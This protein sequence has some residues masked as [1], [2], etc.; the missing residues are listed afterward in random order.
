MFEAKAPIKPPLATITRNVKFNV[1]NFGKNN[2]FP[3][4]LIRAINNSPTAR[5]C[6][7]SHAK[8]IAG[9]GF[10][11]E[12]SPVT[13]TL[14][15]IFDS[16][17]LA[18]MSYDYAYFETIVLHLQFNMN[19]ELVNIG[20]VDASTVRLAEP[21]EDGVIR[22]CKISANWEE[23]VGRYAYLNIPIDYDLYD[24]I[25]TKETIASLQEPAE[26]QKW[27]G[28]IVYAKRYAPGQ[29][30]Y[31]TPSW[32]ASL[33]WAYADGEIQNFHA[34]NI[35]NAFMPSVLV[36]VPGE[37]KGTT[38][39]GRTKRDAFKEKLSELSGAEHGGEPVV[40]YGKEGSQPVITQFNANSNHEL[41]ISL[42]NLITE[43]ITRAFQ[44]PQILAGI[45]TAGQLGTSNEISNSIEL[46]YNTVIKDD[47]NF[48]T[49]LCEDLA[50]WIPGYAGEPIKI[51]NSK[52]FNYI[53]GAFKD[54]YTLG[55]RR[56]ASGYNAEMPP[57]ETI[58]LEATTER[59]SQ[60]LGAL[61]PLVANKVL[62]SMTPDEIR[63][64]VALPPAEG[65]G[66]LPD[67]PATV[68]NIGG[69]YNG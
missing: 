37:L 41:F 55:E 3:Q 18:R 35:D 68:L 30:Y 42:S 13:P 15:K 14:E 57:S 22:R 48:I 28:A 1:I 32:S 23:T 9:D 39:D 27:K 52:P 44:I 6:A 24:P 11:F 36:Y 31:V 58:Q 66:K 56:E 34:N 49:A 63:Q 47:V 54:D 16:E 60:A 10:M 29:P 53:D 59:T 5:A 69:R 51:A 50:R 40:L 45:K 2:N 8:F 7:K 65:G 4:E 25:H 67:A 61:S 64:L 20:H 19:G 43:A 33:N 12:D 21:D 26:F 46:Y 62:E 17:L 38:P